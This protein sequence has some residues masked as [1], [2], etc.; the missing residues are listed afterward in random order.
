[1][2]GIFDTLLY[3]PLFNFLVFLYN[4]AAFGDFGLAIILLTVVI[5][6]ILSPLSVKALR[7][8]R[9]LNE[10]QPKIREIQKKFKD[11]TQK[12]TREVMALY[13]D[14]NTNPFSGCFLLLI[15]LPVLFALYRISVAGFNEGSLADLYSF[16]DKPELL[17]SLF[18]GFFEL[19]KRSIPLGLIA[20]AVQFFQMKLSLAGTKKTSGDLSGKT[21]SAAFA[22]LSG[23]MLYFFPLM[24]IIV[25]LS[26][27]A[28]L[29]LYL[30]ATTAFSIL[31]QLYVN[32][33]SQS[34]NKS[35]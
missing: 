2:T 17:N 30:I 5:R 28:G 4:T 25:S 6:L 24:I 32:K 9:M 33:S 21:Q 7:S 10:L 23:Q 8:Q 1:M 34:R 27:P 26:F 18:L 13:K 29:P 3:N 11:D 19:T 35:I 14:N 20:G 31:E 16:V 12:Q 15:Q 22:G